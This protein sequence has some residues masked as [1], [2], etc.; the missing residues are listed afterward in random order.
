MDFLGSMEIS[1]SALSAERTRLNVIS[2]NLANS[3]TTRTAAGGPYR[4][5]VS[6]FAATPFVSHL[7]R[8]LDQPSHPAQTDPQRGVL[9]E[10]IYYDPAPFRRVY[11][12]HHPD[13]DAEGY[14]DYPNVNVVSEMVNLIDASRN[15]EANVTAVNATKAMAMKSLEIAR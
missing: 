11:D 4:R 9:V 7:E 3:E 5:Q 15:F 6:V 1:A 12:P 2:Q 14:V 10:G 8:A 13:A